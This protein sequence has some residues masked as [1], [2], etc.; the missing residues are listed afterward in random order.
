MMD[1]IF[2]TMTTKSSP[3]KISV[4]EKILEVAEEL[5]EKK[6]YANVSARTIAKNTKI[7]GEKGIS[8]G[9]LY[10]HYPRGKIDIL[11]A[12]GMKYSDILGM[13]EFINSAYQL[14]FPSFGYR[15]IKRL[16]RL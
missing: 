12:I 6:G 13:K 14:K 3:T 11:Q 10:H 2:Y 15:L 4:R 7:T 9:T 1:S 5:I 16:Y 8:V